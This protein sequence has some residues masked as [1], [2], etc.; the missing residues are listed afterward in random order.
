MPEREGRNTAEMVL[1]FDQLFDSVNGYAL[2]SEKSLKGAIS[3]NS[4]HFSFWEK[5]IKRLQKMRFVDSKDKKSLRSSATLRNWIFTIRGFRKLWMI[6]KTSGLEF[7]CL[8]P[9]MLNQDCLRHFFA[10]IRSFGIKNTNPT[11]AEFEN[12]FKTLLINNLTSPPVHDNS[13]HKIDGS[14]LFTLKGFIRKTESDC[15]FKLIENLQL[16][17][18]EIE[19]NPLNETT[20]EHSQHLNICNSIVTKILNNSRIKGC[21]FCRNLLINTTKYNEKLEITSSDKLLREF[22]KADDI[23]TKVMSNFC[24]LHHTALMLETELYTHIDLRWLNCEQ[25]KIP[26]KELLISYIVVFYIYKWCNS[27]NNILIVKDQND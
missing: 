1:F 3:Y 22:E 14:L 13:E 26:L 9:R 16:L 5:A 15:S 2:K 10:Q 18:L 21:D 24:Y 6:M 4:P 20:D 19:T 25:H 27:I 17:E 8:K 23:L 11:C 12:S 7:K